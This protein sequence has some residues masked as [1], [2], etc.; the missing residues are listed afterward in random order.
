MHQPVA[1][2]RPDRPARRRLRHA[3]RPGQRPGRPRARPEVR[4][5]AR[6]PRH[7]R[8]PSTARTS[9]RVWGIDEADLPQAGHLDDGDGP[10]DGDGR[11]PRAARHL[12]Q[13][14]RVAAQPRRGP[15]G[16]DALEFHAQFD[17]FLSET[18]ASAPTWCCPRTVWAEDEGVMTNGEGRVVKHNKAA[19]PPGRGPPRLG[20]IC[21]LARRLGAGR[22]VPLHEPARDLRRAARRLQRRQRRLLRHHLRAGRGD[23]RHLLALPDLDHPGTP[24]L[25]EGGRFYHPDGKARFH[26]VEWQP[27]GRAARRRVPAA[28]DHRP[29]GRPLPVGQ[30]DP[31]ARRPRRAD[32]AARGSR[33]TPRSASPTATRCGSVTRRGGVDLPGAGHRDHPARHRVH[34]RTTGP[35]PV[36]ANVLTIDALDPRLA[37]SPSSRCAP[38][39][40]S[41]ASAVD[42]GARAARRR[43]A[44]SPYR[45]RGRRRS[46]TR[47]RRPRR[48]E[49]ATVASS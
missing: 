16:Y 17:F 12:Q 15:A 37:R 31:A 11:D 14:V 27:A 29:H 40:S 47:A 21:E 36:A 32:A 8:T 34:A 42:A 7:R 1:G 43:R 33:S 9:P 26:A 35:A 41:A 2:H 48:R 38:A 46:A 25:F 24:R 22:Q 5:A 3:H 20:I 23:R 10:P 39:G 44:S 18:A 6:R 28:P 30:P 49:G 13:P 45:A 19:E 4:H